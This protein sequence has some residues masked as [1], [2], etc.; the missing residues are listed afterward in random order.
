MVKAMSVFKLFYALG[1][2]LGL[3]IGTIIYM[4]YG[5]IMTFVAWAVLMA[6]VLPV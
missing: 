4:F 3:L 6:I 2:F 5:H 1:M